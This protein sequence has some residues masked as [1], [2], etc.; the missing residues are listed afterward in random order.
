MLQSAHQWTR[1]LFD[2]ALRPAGIETRH[3]GVLAALAP[4]EQLNQKQLVDRLEL[5]KSA[6]VL[7]LDDLERLGLAGRH[8]HP[9]DRRAHTLQIT[10]EGRRRLAAAQ[11]IAAELGRRIF[12]GMTRSDRDQLDRMLLRIVE[13]CRGAPPSGKAS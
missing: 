11:E 7:I 4:G 3:L 6:V 2:E 10:G 9:S 13:N 8:A 1:R 5:D 12:A